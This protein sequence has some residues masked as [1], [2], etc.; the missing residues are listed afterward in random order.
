MRM[1]VED[2][3]DITINVQNGITSY[4][5]KPRNRGSFFNHNVDVTV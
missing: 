4:R 2:M 5:H 1:S 3:L